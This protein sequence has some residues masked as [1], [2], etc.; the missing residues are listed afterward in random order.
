MVKVKICGLKRV[1]D[2]EIVNNFLPD[3]IGFV[4]APSKRQIN[5]ETAKHL[6]GLLNPTIKSVGVFVNEPLENIVRYEEEGVIDSIQL[7]G[8]ED[9][10]YIKKLKKTSQLPV[11][12]AFKLK[13]GNS[14]QESLLGSRALFESEIIDY[15]LL[16]SYHP[17]IHGGS[18]KCFNWEVLKEVHRPYFLAGGIGIENVQEALKCTPYAID[19]S[20]K[21]ED[22][23]GKDFYKIK[24]LM[25]KVKI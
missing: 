21:V 6:K 16:D 10:V 19:V 13:D 20:S 24:E 23:E 5:L 25:E 9:I 14:L 17:L 7:H 2:I 8:D 15:I 11:I 1:Q 12:K 18:G 22:G 3:Y 4:F